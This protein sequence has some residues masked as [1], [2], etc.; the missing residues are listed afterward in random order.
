V[1]GT[2][3]T[4]VPASESGAIVASVGYNS[5]VTAAPTLKGI[6]ASGT[7]AILYT[8]KKG[9]PI[10]LLVQVD[11]VTAQT[12]LASLIGG[13]GVQ[14]E[15]LQ[16]HRL[17]HTEATARA[18]ARLTER[19]QIEVAVT[20]TTHDV[21]TIPGRMVSINLPSPTNVSGDFIL[22]SVTITGFTPNILPYYTAHASSTQFSLADLLRLA[23]DG[24]H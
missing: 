19:N 3:L 17:S 18:T 16:D 1:A 14:E 8:I 5:T 4:G 24:V 20:F 2:S 15:Y 6:P 7:G 21:N 9:D 23:T 13:D 12:E 10:N 22:Q 11:D